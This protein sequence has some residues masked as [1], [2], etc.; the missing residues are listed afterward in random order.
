MM[1]SRRRIG[2]AALPLLVSLAH[3][4]CAA[5]PDAPAEAAEARSGPLRGRLQARL[6]SLHASGSTPGATVG[7][8]LPDGR[9]MGLATGW[10]DTAR[11]V[12]MTPDAQ[13][14]QGSVGKTYAAAVAMQL[15]AEGKL[16]LAAPI[17][18]YLGGEPWFD[19][20]PN[21][22]EITVRMLMNHTSG[23]QRYE[24]DGR[25]LRDLA[26]DPYRE[27]SPEARL[28]YLFD[29]AAPF[30]AG[31][32]WDYSDTN[33]IVLGMIIE[34]LA[35]RPYYEELRHRIL[36]PLRLHGTV[37]SDRPRLAR[38]AQGYAG[39]DN[40]FGGNDA[41]IGPD[42][43]LAFNPQMEWTGGGIA[44]TAEDLARWAR[45]L[46]EGHAFDPALL[47]TVLDGVPAKLGRDARYG[48]G[49]ILRPTPLGPSYGH[50]GYFPGYLTEVMYFPEHRVA[51]AVQFNTSARGSPE[52]SPAR[53]L[54]EMARIVV[55]EAGSGGRAGA[56]EQLPR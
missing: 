21:A 7:I 33:Y 27:W 26:R 24:F 9:T 16:D 36:A 12:R 1:H 4:A 29:R 56:G 3:G 8:A 18:R 51:V 13:L 28:A 17:S 39:P 32:G 52:H 38:L 15:V 54:L 53:L 55:D 19:R 47:P 44:S 6:D 5:R 45:L 11:R 31:E 2:I 23:L 41:M 40:P 37:P 30:P 43:R 49:V 48:L 35:G 20:L 42:G 22:R 25:F 46:Y 50:S 10:A 14:L 34:R